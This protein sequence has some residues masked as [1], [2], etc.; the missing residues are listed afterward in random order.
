MVIRIG[1]PEQAD[2]R[3]D[4]Y[5][6]TEPASG[7]AVRNSR[8]DEVLIQHVEFQVGTINPL[9]CFLYH[10]ALWATSSFHDRPV[11]A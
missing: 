11:L 10:A 9:N 4:V 1:L 5:S 3:L 8:F 6:L 7:P 2:V